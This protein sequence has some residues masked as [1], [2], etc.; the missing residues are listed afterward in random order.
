M[1]RK[2]PKDMTRTRL[3]DPQQMVDKFRT[4]DQFLES[5]IENA[6]LWINVL[7]QQGNV[8]IWNKA[9]EVMSGYSVEEVRG[10]GKVWEWLYPEE[11][12]RNQ[13]TEQV[14]NLMKRGKAEMD[15]ETKITRKDGKL[16]IMS[17]NER[18]LVDQ[19]GKV[20][21]SIAIGRDIT[22]RKQLEQQL[23]ESEK[24]YRAMVENSPNLIG[25]FQDGVLKYVNNVGIHKLGWTYDEL[26]SPSFDPIEN[27]VSEKSRNLLKENV[28]KRFRGEDVG[29]YEISLTRKDGSEI[30]VVVR[31]ARII[32]DGQTRNSVLLHRS[33]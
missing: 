23:Q 5:V 29:P 4:S 12:Y 6:N 19:N 9:A 2:Y 16:K 32:Y 17:W 14:A 10:H 20:I 28:A 24:K 33:Y 11:D 27:I 7:D 15:V 30:P 26:V 31:A 18:S 25:I 1:S 8:L 3:A 13:I 22:K 21:G